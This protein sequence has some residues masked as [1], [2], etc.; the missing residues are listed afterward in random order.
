M[1]SE[2]PSNAHKQK[3][4]KPE[5]KKIEKVISSE[6]IRRKKPFLKRGFWVFLKGT[7]K[8]GLE[9]VLLDVLVP[10]T[11]NMLADGVIQGAE[12]MIYGESHSRGRSSG[13][14][15]GGGSNGFVNYNYRSSPNTPRDGR[16]EDPRNSM[17][18]RAR[19]NHD[20]DEIILPTRVEAEEVIDRLFELVSKFELASVS[21]LYDLLGIEWDY[22]DRAWGWTD[23]RGAG[24][25]RVRNGYLL[26]LPKPEPID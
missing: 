20:F 24:V 18:R 22:T 21:D 5:P 23:I 11:K 17:S 15:S 10:Q 14:R 2:F 3:A 8:G 25:T 7:V 12:R 19:A 9:F 16:R 4:P 1:E 13:Y 26:D 6:V